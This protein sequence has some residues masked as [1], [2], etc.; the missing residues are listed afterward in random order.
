[1]DIPEVRRRLRGALERAKREAAERRARADAGAREY[2]AFLEQ[3]A[4]PAFRLFASA[5]VGEGRAFK[6]QTPAGSVRLVSDGSAD[7]YI[8]L[9]LDSTQDP[10]RVVVRTS[11]GRGRRNTSTERVLGNTSPIA[12]TTEE[13]VLEILLEE[14]PALVER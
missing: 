3:R 9:S 5:L 12:E 4:V 10:P 7:D 8:D 1:M 11:R 13:H 14:I 6:V 2:D